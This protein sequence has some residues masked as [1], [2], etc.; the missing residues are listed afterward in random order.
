MSFF[1]DI[2]TGTIVDAQDGGLIADLVETVDPEDGLKMAGAID[3]YDAL[4]AIIYAHEIGELPLPTALAD[5]GREALV[6]SSV[7]ERGPR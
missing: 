5:A 1:Y 4:C 7:P 2:A 3:L 6:R